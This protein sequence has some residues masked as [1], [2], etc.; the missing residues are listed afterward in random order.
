[1]STMSSA[2][3]SG[4]DQVPSD[5]SNLKN[6]MCLFIL[7]RKDGI[8]FDVTSVSEEDIMEI[9]IRLGH[10]HPMGVLHYSAMEM[11]ALFCSTEECNVLPTDPLR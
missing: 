6:Q 9:C 1:M 4:R 2:T 3:A 7:T 8:L 11:V 10:T 5:K